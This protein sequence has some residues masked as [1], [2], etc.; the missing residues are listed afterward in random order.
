MAIAN[1]QTWDRVKTLLDRNVSDF[2]RRAPVSGSRLFCEISDFGDRK[3]A[4]PN[5]ENHR[6]QQRAPGA[7]RLA[8]PG[9]HT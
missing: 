8:V 3:T 2:Q 1:D 4:Q 5:T 7:E 9:G 6:K